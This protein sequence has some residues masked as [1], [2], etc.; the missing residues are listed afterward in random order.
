MGGSFVPRVYLTLKALKKTKL[1]QFE[2][3]LDIFIF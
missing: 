1:I 2:V 3:Q